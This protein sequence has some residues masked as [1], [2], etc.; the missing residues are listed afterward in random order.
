MIKSNYTAY[1]QAALGTQI[2]SLLKNLGQSYVSPVAYDTAWVG[3]LAKRYPG[4]GFEKSLEWLRRN[5][6]DD[7]TWGAPLLHYHDRFAST[8]ASIVALREAGEGTRDE[9]RVKRGEAALWKLVSRLGRDDSDTIGFPIITASLAQDAAELGLDVPRPPIR[10]AEGYKRKVEKLLAQS[11]R[12]WRQH[13][14]SHSL[15][16]LWREVR[17]NDQVLEGG[18]FAGGS[19]AATAAYLFTHPNEDA[20]QAL[21]NIMQ[22]GGGIP[23]FAAVDNWEITWVLWQL[24]AIGAIQRDMPEVKVLLERLWQYWSPE[25]GLSYSSLLKFRDLD[26]IA[27]GFIVLRWGGY[28][29]S[30]DVFEYHE[31][32]DHFCTYRQET[33][34]SASVHLRLLLALQF[35][36]EHP[37][38][39]EWRQKVLSALRR[40]DEN[41]SYWWDK[42]HSSPY[43]ASN[44]AIRALHRLD[45]ELSGSRVKWILKTQNDDG[46][47]GYMDQSTPEE[48]AYCLDALL[49]WDRMVETVDPMIITQA[50]EFL[51]SHSQDQAYTPLWIGKG[52]YTPETI[53]KATIWSAQLQY[54][55][56]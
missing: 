32:E 54:M 19:P 16:G 1:D 38:Q 23:G 42:W 37:K 46:G 6:H 12:D 51:S 48:T 15:E 36:P 39:P 45:P 35:C 25:T 43:Y 7:G 31:M 22:H 2:I 41:G 10:H 33:N 11:N 30:A 17:E 14:L 26:L 18:I 49:L 27:C 9:R 13:P 21:L 20:L 55:E 53:V 56:W 29:V 50:A 28:P 40:F 3:R 34:P 4:R 5:Q 24:Q 47:W 44:L 8:L 52:L